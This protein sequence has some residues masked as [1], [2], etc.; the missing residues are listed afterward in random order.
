MNLDLRNGATFTSTDNNIL[1]LNW[2]D[3]LEQVAETGEVTKAL[4]RAKAY[5]DN[6]LADISL[7][8]LTEYYYALL[9]P[10]YDVWQG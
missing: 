4:L 1:E 2:C 8:D 7:T 10:K 5:T 9:P 3:R 6:I